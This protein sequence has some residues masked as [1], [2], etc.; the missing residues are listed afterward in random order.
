VPTK[1]KEVRNETFEFSIIASGVDHADDLV[2]ASMT[3]L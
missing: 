3:R 1:R 2:I